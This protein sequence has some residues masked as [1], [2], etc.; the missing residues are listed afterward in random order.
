MPWVGYTWNEEKT[1][2]RKSIY[3][4]SEHILGVSV[5]IIGVSQ[6]AR[7]AKFCSI[8]YLIVMRLGEVPMV[9]WH[10]NLERGDQNKTLTNKR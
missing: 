2:K 1:L 8:C 10:H 3:E 6:L 9:L 7:K 4:V 5:I